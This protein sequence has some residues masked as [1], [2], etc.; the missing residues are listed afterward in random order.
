ML[1]DSYIQQSAYTILNFLQLVRSFCFLQFTKLVI[2]FHHAK[3]AYYYL[4]K[5]C[6]AGNFDGL[7]DMCL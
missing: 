1:C 3:V 4:E 2:I 6:S 7:N 5:Y